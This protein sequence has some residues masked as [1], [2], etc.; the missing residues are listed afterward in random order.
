MPVFKRQPLKIKERQYFT[1]N[2]NAMALP[3]LVEIQRNS[4]DWFLKFGVKDLFEEVSPMT[5]FSGR[6]LELYLEDYYLDEPRFDE[7]TCRTRNITFEAPLRI[8]ARLVNKRTSA[9]KSQEIY[10]GDVPMM[11]NRGT[12]IV[13][14]IERVVVSQLIRSAGAF[15]TA[16]SVRGRRYY[17]AKMIPNRG[18]WL[19]IETDMNNVMWVKVDRKRKVAVTSLLRA[20]GVE[21]DEALREAVKDVNTHPTIDYMDATIKKDIAHNMGEGLIEV[22]KRIRPGD[23]ATA[24]NA[25]SL[26]YAMFFNFD[27]YD[28]GKVGVYK[29]NTKFD[30]NYSNE[31][32]DKKENRVLSAEKLLLVVKEVIRLNVTQEEADDVDHLGNRRVR[33]VGEL[34]QNRFRVG[35]ARMERIVK[36]RMST[37]NIEELSPNKLINARPVTSAIREF[38]MSSQMSQFMDQTNPLSELEH[39]RRLS[40]LGPGGLSRD[41]AGFEVRD[42]HTTHYGRICPIATPEGPNIG[43]V[44]HLSS[45]AR[46]NEF[47][48]IETPYR[49]VLKE[50]ENKPELLEGEILRGDIE[51]VKDNTPITKDIATKLAKSKLQKISVQPRLTSE[52]V[53]LNSFREEKMITAAATVKT[54]D[55]GH[56]IDV[57]VPARVHGSPGVATVDQLDF[58]DVASS[59]IVSVA[60]SCIPFLE[61]DDATRALMGT[62]MQRQAVPCIHPEPPIVGTGVEHDSARYTGQ[63]VMAEEE[64]EVTEVDGAHIVITTKKGDQHTYNLNKF[65]RS[66]ASTCI[67]QQIMVNLGDKVKKDQPLSTGP[68]VADGEISV[69]QN[70]L[71]AYMAWDG[72]NYEDAVIVS[73]RIVQKDRYTSIHIEDYTTDVRETKLGPELVT[74]DIP[75]VSEEKLKNLDS[76]GIVRV[77]AEVKS[78]DILVGKITPKGE[79]EL[80]AEERLL[81]AIFGEKARDVRDSSLYLEHGEHGKVIGI[82]IF[83]AENGDKLEPGIIKQVQVKVADMRKIQVGDK[84]AGRHGNK[85]VISKVVPAEDMP[86]L[87]DGTPI[88]IILS[89][90][91]VI[92]RMNLG[93]LLETHL[94]LA[95]NALGYKVATPVLNGINEEQIRAELAK[96]GLPVDGQLQLY[97]GRTGESFDTKTTV[98]YNY[99]LKLNHMVEDKIHQRSIGPYSLITQQPLGGKAQFGGQRFGEMEVW[100]IEAYGAAH[101]L[102]E[103]LTIKSDDVPGRSK[104]YEAI[105]KG[106]QIS[107]VNLPE[108]FNVLVRELKGLALD[109]ELLKRTE[110]GEYVLASEVKA[111]EE[112]KRQAEEGGET[113]QK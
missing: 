13:N 50:V 108:S 66:N 82:Q 105:I 20:F 3:N 43:L 89:P 86:F 24:D 64:G 58:L 60:T 6:D 56:F 81:R 31:D 49:K 85:G 92:S 23:L 90:L 35:L 14:G 32:Y 102:Q 9:T 39:K 52:I 21:T 17:G 87:E 11:T 69:G 98:G 99:M 18:A 97:D 83:S 104:A 79:T 47:G 55:N 91:G 94:G 16:E 1:K 76:E 48:F 67:N 29:F 59:Q 73:E 44:N 62:N 2:L 80:S 112:R 110:S 71:V 7:V 38:F 34:V 57:T 75:N 40:A 8:T 109:V 4:Y 12:F 101:T 113:D 61:H 36:D 53:Y 41:R 100:A 106:E 30:L 107:R 28:L 111:A 10:L 37:Y 26:I 22:Y 25:K 51:G 15:F 78:G 27:R 54:D 33:A 42:V 5:D 84:M 93:Q 46:I 103:I 72:F 88:D 65:V 45:F 95:A 19:E 96:A 70:V 63:Q 74:S 68:C 77:G